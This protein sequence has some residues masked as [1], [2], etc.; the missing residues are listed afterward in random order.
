MLM[1]YHSLSDII[2]LIGIYTIT[3]HRILPNVQIIFQEIGN[4]KYYKPSYDEIFSDLILKPAA[5]I[6]SLILYIK[7]N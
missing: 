6:F 3:L 2:L 5:F 7:S 4:F 1:N